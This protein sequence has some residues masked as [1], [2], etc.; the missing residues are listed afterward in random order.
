MNS[1]ASNP[2][3]QRTAIF[4]RELKRFKINIAVLSETQL[5][6]DGQLKEEKGRHTIL[7][8]KT[9][10]TS[11]VWILLLRTASSTTSMNYLWASM[12]T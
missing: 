6:D 5:A 3:E 12:N 9:T 1:K 7:E 8:R 11:M 4:S 2:P 10:H